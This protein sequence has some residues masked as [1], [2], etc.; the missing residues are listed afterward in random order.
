MWLQEYEAQLE[1]LKQAAE[2]A[3][4]AGNQF[5]LSFTGRSFKSNGA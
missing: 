1:S 3:N 5:T 2:A 4:V